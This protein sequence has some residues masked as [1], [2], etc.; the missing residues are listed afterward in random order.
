MEI[1]KAFRV[2][3]AEL[4]STFWKEWEPHLAFFGAIGYLGYLHSIKLPFEMPVE[5][6][7]LVGAGGAE[8]RD[9]AV[10]IIKAWK[11]ESKP[12]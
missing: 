8:V 6:V 2:W 3:W 11:G 1:F 5:L 12:E 4:T 9:M 10:S 7:I